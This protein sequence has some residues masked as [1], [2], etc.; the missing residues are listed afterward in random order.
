MSRFVRTWEARL[1]S[2]HE[3]GSDLHLLRGSY[4]GKEQYTAKFDADN[5]VGFLSAS[6][7][8]RR[9]WGTKHLLLI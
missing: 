8:P 7:P 9:R 5:P 3:N 2:S 4:K 1:E 6:A